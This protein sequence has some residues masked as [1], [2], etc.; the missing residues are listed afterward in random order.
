MTAPPRHFDQ[1]S[2]QEGYLLLGLVVVCFL[3]LLTLAIAAPRVAKQLE[4]DREVES[5]HRAQEYVRAIQLY[6][7]RNHRFP[8]S[9]EELLAT[10]TTGGVSSALQV[11]YLRQQYKDP[12]T[13]GDYRLILVGKAKTEVKGFFG[14]P[15]PGTP[16]AN[17]G[18]VAG[19]QSG[20]GFNTPAAGGASSTAGG[21][22]SSSTFGSSSSFGGAQS[23]ATG[24]NA[25]GSNSASPAT[26]TGTGSPTGS[27]SG[28]GSGNDAGS[29]QGSKGAFLGVGSNAKGHGQVEWNGSENIEDWEFLYDLRVD[30][31]KEK[32]SLFGGTPAANGSGSLGS[33]QSGSATSF[34]GSSSTGINGTSPSPFG[35]AGSASPTQSGTGSTTSTTDTNATPAR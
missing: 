8:S 21:A 15:L 34:G 29:F 28:F 24:A 6:Y 4:R 14:E 35:S 25:A 18:S 22:A 3:L 19:L 10:G 27:S 1:G 26:G 12:L 23:S 13:N 32:V 31:M 16:T 30:A 2:E 11:K 5:E 9:V 20:S 33:L 17:L 7:R